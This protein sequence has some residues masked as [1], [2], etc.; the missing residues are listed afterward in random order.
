MSHPL[1][2][3]DKPSIR[4]LVRSLRHEAAHS[5]K[6]SGPPARTRA[7]RPEGRGDTTGFAHKTPTIPHPCE[8]APDWPGDVRVVGVIAPAEGLLGQ[9]ETTMADAVS[10]MTADA[11]NRCSLRLHAVQSYGPI[12]TYHCSSLEPDFS[13]T[14]TSLLEKSTIHLLRLPLHGSA[15]RDLSSHAV[16]RQT[17]LLALIVVSASVWINL[18]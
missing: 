8:Q 14:P 12:C 13:A 1:T 9:D 18:A 3:A 4:V 5:A 6:S 10:V 15:V 11:P 17:L 16:I 2:P 7:P